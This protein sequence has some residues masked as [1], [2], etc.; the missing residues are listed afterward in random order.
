[1]NTFLMYTTVFLLGGDIYCIIELL[2]RSRTHYSMFFCAGLAMLFLFVI[3]REN[4][5]V[6]PLL[7]ALAA[8]IIITLLEF[9][10]GIVFNIFLGMNVW[11]YSNVPLNIMGQICLPFSLI[12]FAFGL[13]I[14]FIFRILRLA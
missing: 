5:E 11:D 2:Y 8:A 4:R 13:V 9:V 7:F 12:W 6:S 10:F 14:Y 1:M 3:Y